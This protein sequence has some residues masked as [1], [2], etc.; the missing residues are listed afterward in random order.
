MSADM[1]T[2]LGLP[3]EPGTAPAADASPQLDQS[4][5]GDL[6]QLAAGQQHDLFVSEHDAHVAGKH[7]D[8]RV[9]SPS[10]GLYSWSVRRGVPDPGQR[11]LAI[12]QALHRHSYGNWEGE[13]PAGQYG[14]GT[15]K[16]HTQG[17][18]RIDEAT[19]TRIA[20]TRTDPEGQAQQYALLKPTAQGY[21]RRDWILVNTT[22]SVTSDDQ[23]AKLADDTAAVLEK[24]AAA[25]E[26]KTPATIAVDLDGTLATALTPYCADAIG[27]PRPQA[28]AW[29]KKFRQAGARLIVF[30][31]RGNKVLVRDWLNEHAI[32]FDFINENP[33]QPPDASGKVIADV[34]LDDRAVSALGDW[35]EFGTHV[36]RHVARAQTDTQPSAAQA[37]AGNYA[38][39]KFRWCGHEIA[40]ENP[41]GSTRR[42]TDKNGKAWSVVMGS[43]YGYFLGTKGRDKDQVDV[44]IGPDLTDDPD[45]AVF[46]INQHDPETSKFDE[47]KVVIGVANEAAAKKLYLANYQE[48]WQGLGAV[49]TMALPVFEDWLV[50]GDKRKEANDVGAGC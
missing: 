47:H 5:Y 11:F 28:Q 10:T 29:M 31:V 9:G 42:G 46:V 36:L 44:L 32:P 15:V 6:S 12:R 49:K 3:R 37:Q 19:P 21:R 35:D 24:L 22:P 33:D 25:L 30:T 40:I 2:A 16:R 17:Q 7:H 43:D 50:S 14:G 8:V 41:K 4:E 34:Y 48:G 27:K 23:P 13:I 26:Q 18:V 20:F 45:Q 39:G 38:K 1:Q